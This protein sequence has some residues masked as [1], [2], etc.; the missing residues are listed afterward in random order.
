MIDV[1]PMPIEGNGVRLEPLAAEH[2]DG[3]IAAATYGVMCFVWFR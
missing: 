3:L 2:R 1:H